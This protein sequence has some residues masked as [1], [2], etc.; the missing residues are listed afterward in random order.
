MVEGGGVKTPRGLN[1]IY[2]IDSKFGWFL[3]QR[4]TV[5][6]DQW[7]GIII[8]LACFYIF[9]IGVFL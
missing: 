2:K 5:L 4:M 1:I 7:F 6:M 8:M 3:V 9:G